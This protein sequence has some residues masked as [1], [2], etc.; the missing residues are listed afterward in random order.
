MNLKFLNLYRTLIQIKK[1]KIINKSRIKSSARENRGQNNFI[2]DGS[3]SFLI[4]QPIFSTFTK[5]TGLTDTKVE[6][7]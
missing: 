7:K 5:P 3:Q 6:W 2:N 1:Y 4:F